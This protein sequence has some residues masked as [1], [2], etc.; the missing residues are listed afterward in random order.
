M[1]SISF[2]AIFVLILVLFLSIVT[3]FWDV[4]TNYISQIAMENKVLASLL[5][6]FLMFLATVIAPVTATPIIPIATTI[7]PPMLVAVLSIIGWGMGAVIAFIVARRYGKPILARF[8]SLE[9][10]EKYEKK[11]P[12]RLGFLTLILLRMVVPVDVLSYAIGLVSSMRFWPYTAATFIGITPFSF[13]F[14]YSGSAFFEGRFALLLFF[15]G[16]GVALFAIAWYSLKL[17]LR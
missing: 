17:R 6:T 3:F 12:E 15:A 4:P 16:G 13:I 9:E 14:A 11:I 2:L 1:R 5:F 10:L 8:V 7:L